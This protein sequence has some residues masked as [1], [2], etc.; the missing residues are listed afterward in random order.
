M[1]SAR[2]WRSRA[3]A[4]AIYGAASVS[5]AVLSIVLACG[6]AQAPSDWRCAP[7]EPACRIVYIV[8]D[9][10]HAG[11]VLR[12]EDLTVSTLPELRDFPEARFVELSWGDKDYFPDPSPGI[13][14]GLKAAFWSS[15]SVV[16]VVGLPERFESFYPNSRIVEL[17]LAPPAFARLIAYLSHSFERPQSAGAPAQPGLTPHSRFYPSPHKF[18]LSK[19]CNTWVAEALQTAG[20]P[21][22]PGLVI[23][24]EQLGDQITQL[25]ESRPAE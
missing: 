9:A 17:R 10:W 4:G 12:R 15:G 2:A 11:I 24:A 13:S 21:V 1:F 18:S 23:T 8:Y 19:T 25:Q 7:G 20:L 14:L 6:Q 5:I 22:W 16:H 3:I